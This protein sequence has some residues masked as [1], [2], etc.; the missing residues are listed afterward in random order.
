MGF[1]SQIA[2]RRCD[3][4]PRALFRGL[5]PPVALPSGRSARARLHCHLD[6]LLGRIHV[7]LGALDAVRKSSTR[8]I[9]GYRERLSNLKAMGYLPSSG[10]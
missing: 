7:C 4:I 1:A 5:T 2:D 3:P 6:V 8:T 10:G 9:P